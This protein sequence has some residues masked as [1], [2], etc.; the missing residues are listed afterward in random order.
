MAGGAGAFAF[1]PL[2]LAL[3][4]LLWVAGFDIIYATQDQ[5]FDRAAGLRSLVVK[6][7]VPRSLRVGAG[8]ALDVLL[9]PMFGWFAASR[10]VYFAASCSIAGALI[11]EHRS[12]APWTWGRSTARSFRAMRS[13]VV[14]S[15]S[16]SCR[17]PGFRGDGGAAPASCRR[18]PR[19]FAA[20]PSLRL[21]LVSLVAALVFQLFAMLPSIEAPGTFMDEGMLLIY[22][23]LFLKGAVPQR[24]YESSYPPGNIWLLS[25][26]YAVLGTNIHVE[27][28]VGLVYQLALV[29]GFSCSFSGGIAGPPIAGSR[30]V[31]SRFLPLNIAAFAWLGG[32]ALALWR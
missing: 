24:D 32:I 6:L 22:P 25:G 2:V 12:A 26:A 20:L 7:G 23:E 3:A 4:V 17:P 27:R 9:L 19:F 11:Y 16:R 14:F 8:A 13:S 18:V 28:S 29:G 30:F 10:A 15:S 31:F 1:P 21:K 5:E